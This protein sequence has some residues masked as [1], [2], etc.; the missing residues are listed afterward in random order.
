MSLD[1]RYRPKRGIMLSTF[2]SISQLDTTQYESS[3]QSPQYRSKGERIKLNM[4][5]GTV[6]KQTPRK[7]GEK[8]KMSFDAGCESSCI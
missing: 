2:K 1:R 5:P 7:W 8:E 6:I 4:C 3:V